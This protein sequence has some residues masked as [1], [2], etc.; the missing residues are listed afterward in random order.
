MPPTGP[1]TGSWSSAKTASSSRR[2][3]GGWPTGPPNCRP[4]GRRAPKQNPTPRF[5]ARGSRPRPQAAS[6]ARPTS[7]STTAAAAKTAT[8]TSP[9]MATG[10]SRSYHRGASGW[11]LLW[12]KGKQ[13][14]AEG[15][16]ESTISVGVGPGGEAYALDNVPTATS[17]HIHPPPAAPGR[18]NGRAARAAVLAG[19]T[20][21]GARPGGRGRRQLLGGQLPERHGHPQVLGATAAGRLRAAA[22]LG[23]RHGGEQDAGDRRSGPFVHRSRRGT[24]QRGRLPGAHRPRRRQRGNAGALRLRA[25]DALE[26]RRARR[27]QRRRRRGLPRLREQRRNAAGIRRLDPPL[28]P[29]GPIAAPPSLE[30]EGVGPTRAK[31]AAEVNPEGAETEAHFEYLSRA[32]YEDQGESFTGEA[33]ESTSTQTIAPAAG[34]EYRL[35]AHRSPARLPGPRQRSRRSRKRLPFA[36]NRIPLAGGGRKRRRSRR[37][38][39][40]RRALH[41]PRLAGGALGLLDRRGHRHR[42]PGRQRRHPRSARPGLLRVRH[43]GAVPRRAAS[44]GPPRPPTWTRDRRRSTSARPTA[45]SAAR[46]RSARWRP[47]R[48]TATASSPPTS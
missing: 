5:V 22:V 32:D 19:R 7:R 36:R 31:V 16:F 17:G 21:A 39:R 25:G 14:K 41:D 2:W 42:P 43:R 37:R 18:R 8:S 4:A 12:A 1:T 28:P 26:P 10:G 9:T 34:S 3:A 11:E 44:P 47:T 38:Q 23:R 20:R 40:R 24:G 35:H 27:P 13:G 29:P 6:A 15:E 45:W 33:T 46:P 48:P 30:V